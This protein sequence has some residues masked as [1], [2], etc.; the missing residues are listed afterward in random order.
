MSMRRITFLLAMALPLLASQ[1]FAQTPPPVRV[2]GVIERL[3]GS[4]LTV[5]TREGSTAQ[6]TLAPNY[7][8]AAVTK[9]ELADVRPGAYV[10]IAALRPA[11]GPLR[12]QEV[13]I[14][15]ESARG[16]GEGHFPWDLTPESTMTNA[17]VAD[18]VQSV[19][20]PVLRLSPKGTDVQIVVP[21]GVPI[22]TFGPG[23]PSLLVPGAAVFFSATSADGRL[24]AT[25]ILVGKDGVVPPM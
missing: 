11:E 7:S 2:R 1:V 3:E 22:V 4:L 20:G 10:G 5:K 18:V 16:S 12:A 15:P 14:F 6:I 13:L 21:P 9:A 17:A 19:N 25:R 23:D 8:V 24:S